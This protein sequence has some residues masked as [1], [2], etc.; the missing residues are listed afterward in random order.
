MLSSCQL[1]V[2][3]NSMLFFPGLIDKLL[4][5]MTDLYIEALQIFSLLL[6]WFCSSSTR[7]LVVYL[8]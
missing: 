4:D 1:M 8:E 6:P 3:F 5:T 2:E 7:I